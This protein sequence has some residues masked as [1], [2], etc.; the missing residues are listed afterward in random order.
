M[1][2]TITFVTTNQNKLRAVIEHTQPFGV[3]VVA[4]ALPL[5]EPQADSIEAVALSKAK[6]AFQ[7]LGAPVMVEDS[8]FCID[9]L[10]GF[11]GPYAKYMLE[12]I[13]IGGLLNLAVNL[14]SRK[15]RFVS[16]LVYLDQE[17]Q[18]HSFVDDGNVGTLT[19]TIDET[20]CEEAWSD[21]WRI[22][23]PMGAS[24]P[25]TALSPDER[26]AIFLQ[27]QTNSVY[28][29]FG[30]WFRKQSIT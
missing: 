25:L 5:V 15:C 10:S 7:I 3:T 6:Q 29:R 9:E 17:E 16:A 21:F 22:V 30:K 4:K 24:K 1:P 13:G 14:E 26:N 19:R 23:I 2:S 27:W 12:S 11:P 8:G 18:A 20:P 28:T